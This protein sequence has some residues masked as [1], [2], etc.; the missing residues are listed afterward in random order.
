MSLNKAVTCGLVGNELSKQITGKCE[1]SIGRTAVAVGS[2]AAAGAITSG[3]I[4]IGAG[5]VSAPVTV[6]LAVAG[7]VIAGI[8]SLFD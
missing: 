4:I 5:A 8:A 7:G 1:T 6:P 2:G 3:A